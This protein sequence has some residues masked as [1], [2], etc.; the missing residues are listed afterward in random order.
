MT[1]V[2]NIDPSID[3]K[4]CI[5]WQYNNSPKLKALILSKEE[6]YKNNQAKFWQDWYDKVF[7]LE[8]ANDFGLSVWGEILNFSRN[9]KTKDGSLHYLTTEQYRLILKGQLLKFNMGATAPEINKWLSVV[10]AGKGQ[11]YCLDSLDMTAIPIVFRSEPTEEI[12]WLLGNIDF[13]PKP[14]G[15]GYQI[16]VIPDT[17]FGFNGSGLK[18]FNQGVFSNDYSH[19]LIPQ[20]GEFQF[21]ITAPDGATVTING[22]QQN[23]CL[24]TEG[25]SYTWNVSRDGYISVS[26]SGTITQDVN[27]EISEFQLASNTSGATFTLNGQQANGAYFQTGTT[28][29]YSYSVSA[30]GF[31]TKTGTGVALQTQA[32]TVNLEAI[33][34]NYSLQDIVSDTTGAPVLQTLNAP[35]TG[36]YEFELRAEGGYYRSSYGEH[37]GVAAFRAYLN[38]G[39]VITLGKV[40]GSIYVSGGDPKHGGSGVYVKINDELIAVAG[41]AAGYDRSGGGG[42]RG[43]GGVGSMASAVYYG[44]SIDGTLANSSTANTDYNAPGAGEWMTIRG[45]GTAF[46]GSGYGNPNYSVQLIT[47]NSSDGTGNF[48]KGSISINYTGAN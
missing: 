6:W 41:G 3:L 24:L 13:F 26:G 14:A 46:G 16:R 11:V 10:F 33:L 28:F 36:Y 32:L 4:Q 25:S 17:V 48:G 23:Y 40:N 19:V 1:Q 18:P 2:L 20:T 34:W 9:V 39:D 44:Y 5:L 45:Y 21:S 43:G 47:G 42:Y 8:T 7:N 27:I 22:V 29:S 38:N 12:G 35:Y 15:V 30:I 31:Y 37:G